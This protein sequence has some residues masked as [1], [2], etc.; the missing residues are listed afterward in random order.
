M[1]MM[2]FNLKGIFAAALT[3]LNKDLSPNIEAMATHC[4]DLIGKGCNGVVLFGTTGEGCSF[5]VEERELAVR[6]LIDAGLD[7]KRI[8]VG[9]ICSAIS[10]AAKLASTAVALN[11]AAV[12]VVPPF[13]L[14]NVNE[15]GVLAFYR[16][17]IQRVNSPNLKIILYHIPQVSGV[18]ITS[19]MI[20]ILTKE[21]PTHIVGLKESEGNLSFTK[22]ILSNF[23][24]FKVF[25]GN[26]LHISEAVELGAGGGNFWNC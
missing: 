23:P 10:D 25:V 21:Y 20:K 16:E 14:K 5:S 26:E 11:C 4:K 13:F 15:L 19:N 22:E 1:A 9:I 8:I 18:P 17:F 7:P 2:N 12:L 3:P 24:N 6:S